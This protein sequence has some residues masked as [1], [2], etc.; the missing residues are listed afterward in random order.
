MIDQTDLDNRFDY[1]APESSAIAGHET[2][3]SHSKDFV[4]TINTVC[5][6]SREKSLAITKLEEVLFWANAA[7]A[8]MHEDGSRKCL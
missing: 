5:P 7:V 2:L 1:H 6:D 3:R 4:S 8:R